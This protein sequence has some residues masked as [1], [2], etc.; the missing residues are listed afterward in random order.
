MQELRAAKK[1]LWAAQE[2]QQAEGSSLPC[3]SRVDKP[4]PWVLWPAGE[5]LAALQISSQ[6]AARL[7]WVI[8]QWVQSWSVWILQE[9]R[10]RVGLTTAIPDDQVPALPQVDGQQVGKGAGQ[11]TQAVAG[12]LQSLRRT[13]ESVTHLS[14]QILNKAGVLLQRQSS[15]LSLRLS[16]TKRRKEKK[17]RKN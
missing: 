1:E 15:A 17:N 13:K 9:G 12:F 11:L 16:F 4:N 6:L 10:G 5:T 2:E 3:V 14:K 8:K 7:R